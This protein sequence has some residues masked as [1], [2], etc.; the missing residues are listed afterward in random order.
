[1]SGF[2]NNQKRSQNC[3]NISQLAFQYTFYKF[4][5]WIKA[6]YATCSLAKDWFPIYPITIGIPKYLKNKICFE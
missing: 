3:T 1:M 6:K 4:T 5:W 2:G